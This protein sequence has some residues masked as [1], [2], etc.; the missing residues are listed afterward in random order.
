MRPRSTLLAYMDRADEPTTSSM[1]AVTDSL[2]VS[3]MP[4]TLSDVNDMRDTLQRRQRVDAASLPVAAEN[5]LDR[6]RMV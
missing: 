3:V 1:C 6:F 4:S 5:E 2:S